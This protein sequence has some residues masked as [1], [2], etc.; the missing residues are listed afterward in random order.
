MRTLP[1]A[2]L[3]LLAIVATASAFEITL[4][5]GQQ[6]L[7]LPV[8]V[9]DEKGEPVVGA[10]VIPW[11]LRSGQGHGLW[12][13][14][15]E[16]SGLDPAS[17]KTD[18]NGRADISYPRYRDVVEQVTTLQVSLWIDQPDFGFVDDLHIDV[19]LEEV[20][21]HEVRLVRGIRPTV[22]PLIDGKPADLGSIYAIWSDGRSWR[23]G[24]KIEPTEDGAL[25]FPAMAPGPVSMRLVRLE[26]EHA[27]HFSPINRFELGKSDPPM[28]D[29]EL[30]PS[31]TVYGR[32]DGEVPRPVEDG[33]VKVSTINPNADDYQ[34][35]EEWF[36]W[37]PIQPDGTFVIK[38][39]PQGEALQLIA[40][41][42]GHYA[43]NGVAPKVVEDP[44][45]PMIDPYNRPQVFEEPGDEPII[46]AMSQTSAC[47]ATV[48]DA[49]GEAVEGVRVLANPNVGW[50]NSGSQIYC[51]PLVRGERLLRERDYADAVDE[52]HPYPFDGTTDAAG[53]ATVTM[54]PG[55]GRL[56]V[57]SDDYELPIFIGRRDYDIKTVPGQTI[58]VTLTVQKKGTEQLG[59]W[60]KLA[61]VVFGCSTR[62][63]RQICAK[64]GVREKMTAF[65]ERLQS[66]EN[67]RDPKLLS[68]LYA[69]VAEAFED[70]GDEAEAA[71]WRRKSEVQ[72]ELAK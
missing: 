32:L 64:P 7:K 68:E 4:P 6:M 55:N 54:L 29:I 43:T 30:Q 47:R 26:G 66:A 46:V 51:S 63:G 49:A 72:A 28:I 41:C 44:R 38:G 37:A 9:V 45:D 25:R 70:Y 11:A 58:D 50:W 71:N 2:L 13:E 57:D 16:R 5:D 42:R 40:L 23:P 52:G 59:D 39:W 60:D 35:F 10:K 36:T 33:R 56:Y 14:G 61:G 34:A 19:P 21:S 24:T 65:R 48:R 53:H 1:L 22:R 3:P 12:R 20:V 27:T 17:V 67:P 8:R 31:A 15:D 69:S 18:A 62:E